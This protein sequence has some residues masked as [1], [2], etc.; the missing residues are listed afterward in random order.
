MSEIKQK[1]LKTGAIANYLGLSR[2]FISEMVDEEDMP[3]LKIGT[4]TTLFKIDEVEQWLK[5]KDAKMRGG[6]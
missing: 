6:E 3:C 2:R 5:E 1:Y 4:R